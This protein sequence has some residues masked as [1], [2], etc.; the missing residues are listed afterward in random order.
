VAGHEI[1]TAKRSTS[2]SRT[3]DE[4]LVVAAAETPP[5]VRLPLRSQAK[6]VTMS[7]KSREK[8]DAMAR[9]IPSP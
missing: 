8:L 1:P 5:R 6:T 7:N 3:K 2:L 9:S 4:G